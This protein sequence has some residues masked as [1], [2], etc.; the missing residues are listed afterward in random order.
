MA[1]LLLGLGSNLGNRQL[2]LERAVDRLEADLGTILATSRFLPTAPVGGPPNQPD[3]LN[4]VVRLTTDLSPSDTLLRCQQIEH[5]LGRKRNERWGPRTIDI[6]L[7][8]YGDQVLASPELLVPHPRLAFRRFVMEPAVEIA[9]DWRHPL[10]GVTLSELLHHWQHCA[11]VAWLIAP[12]WPLDEKRRWREALPP[13]VAWGE[14]ADVADSPAK[15]RLVFRCQPLSAPSPVARS[16]DHG[17]T[18]PE[19]SN[20]PPNPSALF[21]W[22]VAGYPPQQLSGGMGRLAGAAQ[23]SA[24]VPWLVLPADFERAVDDLV[25]AL[26]IRPDWCQ[27][28]P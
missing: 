13:W 11:P 17:D 25:A 28:S 26:Q 8:F 12:A 9:A 2:L 3:F 21:Y 5:Q 23:I 7:L 15:W 4:A 6:D 20:T 14:P 19:H 27:Y 10:F 18:P 1:E 16:P 24:G 22:N